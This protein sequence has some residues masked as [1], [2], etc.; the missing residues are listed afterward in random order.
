MA[1]GNAAQIGL[2][3]Q[4]PLLRF[5]LGGQR[6]SLWLGLAIVGSLAAAGL[7]A[8]II[9]G[10]S[11]SKLNVEAALESPSLAHPFGTDQFGRDMFARTLYAARIDFP[12]AL[13]LV[14]T[15]FT[16]GTIIG[17]I[18][19]WYGG[20]VDAVVTRIIDVA[21][22]F[23]VLVL[24]ISIIGVRGPGLASLYLAVSLFSWVFYAR[25]V[26]GEVQTARQA[27]YIKAARASDFST[28]RIL[29]RHLAPNIIIQPLVYASSDCVYALL[30]GASVS[31]LSLG[32][33]PPDVEWGQMV[34]LGVSYIGDQWWISTFPG[35]TI[36]VAG[37]AF[38]LIADGLTDFVRSGDR[39]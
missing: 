12:L 4:R 22:A 30:L 33:Q 32:V 38:S 31:F 24:V 26:R 34:A 19:G 36:A 28:L 5:R 25:L 3:R 35:L 16:V 9:T 27:D 17:V 29:L 6:A 10:Q 20:L 15:G 8:P 23:P 18:A 13:G 1:A 21:L 7:L 2:I 14:V 39:T 11:P 37:T